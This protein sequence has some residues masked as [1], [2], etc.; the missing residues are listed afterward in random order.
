[1]F[2]VHTPLEYHFFYFKIELNAEYFVISTWTNVHKYWNS[3]LQ[4][5]K[6]QEQVTETSGKLQ[7]N[8]NTSW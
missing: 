6:Y 3:V 4:S 1:M 7:L 2:S 5:V 8:F